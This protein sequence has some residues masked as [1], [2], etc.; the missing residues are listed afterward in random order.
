MLA[1]PSGDDLRELIRL[2]ESG[3]LNVTINSTFPFEQAA[4]AH[5][6]VEEGVDRGKVVLIN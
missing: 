4:Q 3:K 5:R 2:Y 1:D 6:R